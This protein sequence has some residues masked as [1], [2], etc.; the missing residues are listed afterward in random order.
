MGASFKRNVGKHTDAAEAKLNI[1]RFLALHCPDAGRPAAKSTIGY[2]A[3]PGYSFKAPQGAAFAVAKLVSE[4]ERDAL[5][6]YACRRTPTF[7][8]GYYITAQG[9]QFLAERG[10]VPDG[11]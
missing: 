2:A 4:L 10:S 9:L 8:R 7:R 1:L 6:A 11:V 5:I 3:Y